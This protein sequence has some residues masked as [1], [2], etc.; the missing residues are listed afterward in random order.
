MTICLTFDTDHMSDDNM[1]RFMERF[2]FCGKATFFCSQQYS[3]LRKTT[4]EVAPHPYFE[5]GRAVSKVVREY[6][7]LFPEATS[8]R[9]HSLTFSQE[10][11]VLV[12]KSGY[13]SVSISERF[14]DVKC[15]PVR[16][17]WGPVD[18]PIYYMDNA[19]FCNFNDMKDA[20]W[21]PFDTDLIDR[22][23]DLNLARREEFVFVFDFHPIHMEL[24]STSYSTYSQERDSYKASGARNENHN[25]R[26]GV[27]NFYSHL[28]SAMK[29][30]GVESVS[31][32]DAYDMLGPSLGRA[33][34]GRM[35]IPP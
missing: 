34:L 6:R 28:I 13:K 17:P 29:A 15:F 9:S 14:G 30:N 22:L 24:N 35:K 8:W 20:S 32:A 12:Q 25:R 23:F 31:I 19:D 3:S 10:L 5:P 27:T 33:T 1:K 4:H 21:R 11:C 7:D 18:F 26:S 16:L 2:E